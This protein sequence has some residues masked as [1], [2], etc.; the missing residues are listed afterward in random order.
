MINIAEAIM[1]DRSYFKT[2]V[3]KDSLLVNYNCP[4]IEQW[5]DLYTNLNHIIYTVSGERQIVR[6]EKNVLA[7]KGSL[8]FLGKSA[9]QQGKFHG[10]DWQVIVF[11]IDDQYLQN[12][13]IEFRSRLPQQAGPGYSSKE[14][15]F[16]IST[17]DTLD[18]FFYG[19]L[20]Y[21]TQQTTPDETLIQLKLR[22][23]IF[24]I[25]FDYANSHLL[26]F[27]N[28]RFNDRKSTFIHTMESNYMFNLSLNEFAKLTYHSL[29]S[30]KK[31]FAEIFMTTPGKWL[32]QKRLILACDILNGSEKTV[33]EIALEIGFESV[34]HF[35]R[36]FK[37][38]YAM[39]PLKYR[40]AF[41][42]GNV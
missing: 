17:T 11:C 12:F 38:R 9:F 10:E 20:P 34:T 26:S 19:L 7:K 32:V 31:E 30:F 39:P 37:E 28:N 27:L 6:P 16:E 36:V 33:A 29:T 21:F 22:E 5:T 13:L 8:I 15:L 35:N 4:Q 40:H 2:L 18:A 42:S 14:V 23:L 1:A 24:N 3:V 25:L 41:R